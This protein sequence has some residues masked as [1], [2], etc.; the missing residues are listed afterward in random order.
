[1]N[2]ALNLLAD[3]IGNKPR[4]RIEIL[5]DFWSYIKEEGLQDT[6]RRVVNTDKKLKP[7]LG[8]EKKVNIFAVAKLVEEHVSLVDS[9]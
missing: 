6:R 5:Q 1:M 2:L 3:I 9:V 8:D 7:I 4:S